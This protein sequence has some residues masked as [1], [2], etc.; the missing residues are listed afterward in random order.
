MTLFPNNISID[1]FIQNCLMN[2]ARP[3]R[4]FINLR[5]HLIT[6]HESIIS[7]Q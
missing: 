4:K 2:P 1:E 7:K 5:V 6:R 3:A